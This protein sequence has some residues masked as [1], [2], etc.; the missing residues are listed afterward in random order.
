M[1]TQQVASRGE[2]LDRLLETTQEGFWYIDNQALTLD[3]NPAMCEILGRPRDE[4]IGRSIY[5][6]VDQANADIFRQE[7]AARG[8]GKRGSYEIAL[9]RPN[10]TN[11]P[12]VNNA[13]AVLD[14][15]GR[16]VASIGLWTDISDLKK[17]EERAQRSHAQLV[18]AIESLPDGVAMFDADER[19]VLCNTMYHELHPLVRDVMVPGA[20]FE[21]IIRTAAERGQH[22]EVRDRD[23]TWITER[24]EA[25]RNPGEPFE[26]AFQDGRW[27]RVYERKMADGGRIGV[28]T[29]ITELKRRERQLQNS[30]QRLNDY[31][32]A[33][34][35]WY[36]E[37][38]PDCRFSFFS[39]RFE[40]VTGV[41][42]SLLLGKTREETGI[43]DVE[44]TAWQEHLNNLA[45]RRSFRD[46]RHRRTRADGS[47]VTLSIN[48]KAIFD[49]EG[50]FQ[51][52]RGT[53]RDITDLVTAERQADQAEALLKSAV[54]GLSELFV[55]WD[56]DDRLVLCNGVFR[57][58]NAAIVEFTEPGTPLEA[59]LRAGIERG[60]FPE[61]EGREEKWLAE[62][63]ARHR[64]AGPP[65]ETRRQ[66]GR[67]L[68]ING[69]RMPDG[70]NVTV[71][72]DITQRKLSEEALRL[73]HDE[74]EERV[75][76]RT[77][78]LE[79]V[80]RDLKESEARL[81][82]YAEASADWF[83][84][85]D[86]D[87]RFTYMSPNIERVVGLPP[88]WHYGKT[89]QDILS[90]EFDPE[91]WE[92]H[93][94]TLRR[95][96]PF[97]DFVF[98]RTRSN[99]E[100]CWHSTSGVPVFD[101]DGEFQSYRG[102]G[103]DITNLK[104]AEEA[105]RERQTLLN[106]VVENVPVSLCLKDREGRFTLVSPGFERLHGVTSA[107]VL[108]KTFFDILPHEV[109][110]DA[111]AED[112][113]VIESGR[114]LHTDYTWPTHL[115]VVSS[116]LIIKFPLRTHTDG[117]ITGVGVIALDVSERKKAEL[118]LR[119]S[120]A[121][122]RLIADS[123]P[124]LIAYLDRDLRFQFANKTAEQWYGRPAAEI[125]GR[126]AA[127]VL[128]TDIE[129]QMV[130]GMKGVIAGEITTFEADRVYPDGKNRSVSV[131]YVPDFDDEGATRGYIGLVTD[132]SGM[133]QQEEILRRAQKME[134]VGQL[135][136]GVAHDFNNLMAIIQGNISYLDKNLDPDSPYKKLTAPALR[137]VKRG[138]SLTQRLLAFS[139]NQTLVTETVDVGDMVAELGEMLRRSL[140]EDLTIDIETAP[141][142]WQCQVDPGQLE[143]AIV[144]LANNARDAMPK[145][146]KLGIEASNKR[147]KHGDVARQPEARAGDYVV[148]SVSDDGEGMPP[149]VRDRVLE[150]FYTTKEAGKGTG[151]G[152]SMVYGFIQQTGGDIKIETEEGIGTTVHLYV[153]AMTKD[154]A[155][156]EKAADAVPGHATGATILVVEDDDD[157]RAMTR[158]FL[159]DLGYRVLDAGTGKEA[160][161]IF[162]ENS[163]IE[164]LLSDVVLPGG[165]SGP[166]L[167]FDVRRS[168]PDLKVVYMSG[169]TADAL[170]RRG[171]I[172]ADTVL[173][174]KPFD[175]RILGQ[176]LRDALD[177]N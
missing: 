170:T 140:G 100:L 175:D 80:N 50:V 12:C 8:E 120:E 107:E 124:V 152:L 6:F 109:A 160:L 129:R 59:H 63:I 11:V 153:P 168:K 46:F 13:T 155:R 83:W 72:M 117:P 32:E 118:A 88:E 121:Q 84:E 134:A 5:D 47:V 7:I 57:E 148:I 18:D 113:Q 97:R 123:L 98:C 96:E 61:S 28:R 24:L 45:A 69:Q 39:D 67:W 144:N 163:N 173:I 3:V 135:T 33:S 143:Q 103:R 166:D 31:L 15:A 21:E 130:A 4:I 128:G 78:E 40:E 42:P 36:W 167:A 64:E 70:S 85:M 89:R 106:A 132:I 116:E 99:A 95:H 30:E 90:D 154:E 27:R 22:V 65:F 102:S 48:G 14:D 87:L 176:R 146:G 38:D 60:L 41:A 55:L 44:P 136:G 171:G 20:R 164:L 16:K 139:R 54:E 141:D 111:A 73:S 79:E 19:L 82:D 169:Y 26:Q 93:C 68:L 114:S 25:F 35:D 138:A 161:K 127:Q 108:G 137:A 62:R 23:E 71:G 131:T 122:I 151:L 147:L 1:N 37:M 43:Q 159:V 10:G 58:I 177:R 49:S 81:Q 86:R 172:D 156:T 2:I 110:A 133:R 94:E 66:D 126:T 149:N 34:S 56:R 119:E 112:R 165:M 76:L 91:A 105:L 142:L 92:A 157:L 101:Q 29:D 51:G 75:R 162:D 125:V 9:C 53:G 150:P 77:A 17:A 115:G 104:A 145:G 158:M 74:L 52:Y 174:R